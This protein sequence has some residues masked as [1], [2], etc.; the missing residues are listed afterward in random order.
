MTFATT[1]ASHVD[2]RHVEML[3]KLRSIP[4]L[5]DKGDRVAIATIH[6]AARNTLFGPEVDKVFRS[7]NRAMS[8]FNA[9][10]LT[11]AQAEA[12]RAADLLEA[13]I[14]DDEAAPEEFKRGR[15]AAAHFETGDGPGLQAFEH[16]SRWFK[17]GFAEYASAA[18]ITSDGAADIRNAA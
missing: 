5:Y 9:R 17:Y 12:T 11:G 10:D 8:L 13:I 18:G 6:F 2:Q 16:R 1:A 4:A 15:W 14:H 7:L 3:P